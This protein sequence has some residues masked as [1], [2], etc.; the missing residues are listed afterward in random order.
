LVDL[1]DGEA[2]GG[3][4]FVGGGSFQGRGDKSRRG[5]ADGEV[6]S[7]VAF[8]GVDL[9]EEAFL[10]IAGTDADGSR[11]CW[12]MGWRRRRLGGEAGGEVFG[13]FFD[14]VAEVA[15]VADPVDEDVSGAADAVFDFDEIPLAGEFFLEGDARA[16]V[17]A[18][19]S[20]LASRSPE[21]R[22]REGR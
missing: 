4:R 1:F 10:E 3:G 20:I 9:E 18:M 15:I 21:P 8:P 17:L 22:E 16:A 13:D 7:A 14:G 5:R 12:R 2:A 11:R 6:E 19:A